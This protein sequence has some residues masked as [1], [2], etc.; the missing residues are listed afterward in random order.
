MEEGGGGRER[1]TERWK[2]FFGD[3]GVKYLARKSGLVK[4]RFK[5]YRICGT[6]DVVIKKPFCL[7][8]QSIC[9]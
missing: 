3:L 4:E 5:P 7:L 9:S 8:I 1:G 6:H 2:S